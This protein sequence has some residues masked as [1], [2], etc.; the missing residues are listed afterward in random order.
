MAQPDL[1]AVAFPTLDDAQVAMLAHV[2][3]RRMLR[4]GEHLFTAGDRQFNFFVVE[5]GEVDVRG[6][7]M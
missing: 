5:R 6:I 3:R 4:D 2:G 7:V 1:R